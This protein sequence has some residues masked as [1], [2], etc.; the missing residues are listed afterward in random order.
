M[1]RNIEQAVALRSLD[2]LTTEQFSK[3]ISDLL[4]K[5]KGLF[6]LNRLESSSTS[7]RRIKEEQ[8]TTAI[9]EMS[10][11]VL[12]L[13]VSDDPELF[14][15][16]ASLESK[17]FSI[18]CK[19]L[20][21]PTS[22]LLEEAKKIIGDGIKEVDKHSL[23]SEII[24]H[25]SVQK[26]TLD[27]RVIV[28]EDFLRVSFLLPFDKRL[29]SPI[30]GHLYLSK[31]Q[32]G[33][34]VASLM[35]EAH[36]SKKA[37]DRAD[38]LRI[39]MESTGFRTI[40]VRAA[41]ALRGT[42]LRATTSLHSK[43]LNRETIDTL[44]KM[45]FPPCARRLLEAF[46]RQCHLRYGGREQLTLFLKGI[47]ITY[48]DCDAYMGSVFARRYGL[49]QYQKLY[50]YK[51]AHNYGR[52]GK[53]QEYTPYSCAIILKA[54][55]GPDEYHGCPFYTMGQEPLLAL[56]R[57]L[58]KG[59][60]DETGIDRIKARRPTFNPQAGCSELFDI[61]FPNHR[62]CDPSTHPTEWVKEAL[63]A[64]GEL[65]DVEDAL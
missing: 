36:S 27:Q 5:F 48:E 2:S 35:E 62:V 34:V 6:G 56:L 38:A 15:R 47:G 12:H 39:K 63:V 13:A 4:V 24:N 49:D 61:L 19:A 7:S 8:D 51:V 25:L 41:E 53:C 22:A 55:P 52:V 9:D 42:N 1:L 11:L 45:C 50:H 65:G 28:I 3:L 32:L 59:R 10:F 60:L 57:E 16:H 30:H 23:S 64:M 33:P 18:R 54:S 46:N 29:T 43:A 20:V 40:L 17:L 44:G 21:M 14:G 26:Q 58:Y 37:R 31:E